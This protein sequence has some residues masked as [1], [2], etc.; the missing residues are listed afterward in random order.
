MSIENTIENR[1]SSHGDWDEGARVSQQLKSI[2]KKRLSESFPDNVF[3]GIDRICMKLSRIAVG[4]PLDVDHWHD[5]AGYA[6]MVEKSL[7]ASKSAL[8]ASEPPYILTKS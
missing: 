3:E 1:K 7:S 8:K 2:I 4:D 6:T 5:I